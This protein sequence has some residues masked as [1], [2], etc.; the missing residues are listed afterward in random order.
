QYNHA[1][2]DDLVSYNRLLQQRNALLKQ[3]ARGGY[4]D[5]ALWQVWDEQLSAYGHKVHAARKIFIE[6]FEPVFSASY[7]Y[8]TN[9]KEQA[10]ISYSSSL[11]QEHMELVLSKTLQKDLVLQY[12]SSGIHKDDLVLTLNGHP[13]KR[14]G[15]QGQQKSVILA[16]K[17]AQFQII[18]KASGIKPILLLDDIF[19][20]LDLQRIT[21]L[22]E[23]VSKETFG[24]LFITDTQEEH[25]R[26]VFETI[27]VPLSVF[28][29]E[30]S[31]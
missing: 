4:S 11:D 25:V 15:S 18:K 20:K 29:C 24:Q 16:L 19:D 22:M 30:I 17:L 13:V 10:G 31:V 3:A 2:L 7:T 28:P 21:R 12:T 8:L 27:G 5:P 26:R 14:T 1:Y 6:E 23:L 9:E